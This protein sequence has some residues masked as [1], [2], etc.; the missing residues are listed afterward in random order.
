[1]LRG[2]LGIHNKR[3]AIEHSNLFSYILIFK[4]ISKQYLVVHYS[5]LNKIKKEFD[6][7]L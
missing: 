6:L 2:I 7:S 4:Q 3:N 5:I 1:M